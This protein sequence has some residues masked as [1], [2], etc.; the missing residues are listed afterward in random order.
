MCSRTPTC[1]IFWGPPIRGGSAKLSAPS[2]IT[3]N[4]FCLNSAPG[5]NLRSPMGVAE[6]E[7][8]IVENLPQELQASL[9][10]VEQIEAEIDNLR[11]DRNG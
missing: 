11:Q 7:T 3:S 10:T 9:P 1:L 8:A 5:S 2:S 4:D 6:W